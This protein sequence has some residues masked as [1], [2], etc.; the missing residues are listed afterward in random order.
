MS[1]VQEKCDASE[2]SFTT[3]AIALSSCTA[4]LRKLVDHATIDAAWPYLKSTVWAQLREHCRDV[5]LE[6]E[7]RGFTVLARRLDRNYERLLDCLIH[8]ATQHEPGDC[9]LQYRA[10]FL[11]EELA[12]TLESAA[13][14]PA[15]SADRTTSEFLSPRPGRKSVANS[16]DESR[17]YHLW[18]SERAADPSMTYV[19]FAAKY[20]ADSREVE[21]LLG[22]IHKRY[23]RQR[24]R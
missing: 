7:G 3:S 19:K 11:A 24:R 18:R 20:G 17:I 12:A 1:I 23:A 9:Q 10:Q 13:K 22:R 21:R 6:L 8:I 2:V 14:R 15:K 5:I 16:N 4:R